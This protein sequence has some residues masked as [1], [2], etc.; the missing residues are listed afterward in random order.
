MI[1]GVDFDNTIISYDAVFHKL[2]YESSLIP[3]TVSKNKT[4]VRDYLR[5]IGQE[6]AWTELQGKVYGPNIQLAKPFA[7]VLEFFHKSK[8]LGH[9]VIIVSHKTKFPYAGEKYDLHESAL[10]WLVKENFIDSPSHLGE[11][12]FFENT[13][14]A[15]LNLINQLKCDWFIDD[16]PEFLNLSNFSPTITKCLFDPYKNH[17]S[18]DTGPRYV[19]W[20]EISEKILG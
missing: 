4:A 19:S 11:T 10:H 15:K 5:K 7:N 20:S 12:L 6:D 17:E 18:Y 16:L 1:I 9:D 8:S 3:Q 14:D 13:K 2:A